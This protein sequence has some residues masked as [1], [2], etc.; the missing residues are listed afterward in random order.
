MMSRTIPRGPEQASRSQPSAWKAR[1]HYSIS[2]D[3]E[4]E[5][6]RLAML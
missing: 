6:A 2:I 4:G 5:Q 3:V 1:R